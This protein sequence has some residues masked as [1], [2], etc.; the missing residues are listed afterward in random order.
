MSKLAG[1]HAV[2]WAPGDACAAAAAALT[3]FCLVVLVLR[4]A[5]TQHGYVE[6]SE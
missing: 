5:S 4:I 1:L 2:A 6:L 3:T